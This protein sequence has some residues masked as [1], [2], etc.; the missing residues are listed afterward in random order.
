MHNIGQED[1]GIR[2]SKKGEGGW[3]RFWT[4]LGPGR[5][6]LRDK[7]GT[8]EGRRGVVVVV[9]CGE[10]FCWRLIACT[11]SVVLLT[12]AFYPMCSCIQRRKVPRPIIRVLSFFYSL[13]WF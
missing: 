12:G 5:L 3:W 6:T 8:G 2:G 1:G 9:D 13:G 11:G 7:R 10:D 4:R